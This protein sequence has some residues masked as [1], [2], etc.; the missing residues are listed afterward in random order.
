M[1]RGQVIVTG[2]PRGVFGEGIIVGTPKP[3]TCVSLLAA[4]EPD[5]GGR[6]SYEPWNGGADGEQSEVII[7]LEDHLQGY[8][9]DDAYVTGSRCFLYWPV[10]GEE[11]MMLLA[12]I[13]GTADD[14]AIGEKLMI[15]DG[16][17]KLI[18]TTGSPEMEPFICLETITDPTADDHYL[19]RYTGK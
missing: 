15:D 13:A 5:G 3:G 4:T 17:G 10:A 19:V 6:F 18:A 16:T 11:F 1:S 2:N 9:F 14:H 12:N 7:L 8:T